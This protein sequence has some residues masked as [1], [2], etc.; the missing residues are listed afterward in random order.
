MGLTGHYS[1][2]RKSTLLNTVLFILCSISP[3]R[4]HLENFNIGCVLSQTYLIKG[5]FINAF[6]R[7]QNILHYECILMTIFAFAHT[8][9]L[10]VLQPF[11]LGHILLQHIR[12]RTH[13]SFDLHFIIWYLNGFCI[14]LVKLYLF[15]RWLKFTFVLFLCYLFFCRMSIDI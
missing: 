6:C 15:W 2:E 13:L 1:S 14:T 11:L 7:S 4:I 8:L 5:H 9:R 10:E 3:L 12:C